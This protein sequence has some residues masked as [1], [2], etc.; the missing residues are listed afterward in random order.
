MSFDK[1]FDYPEVLKKPAEAAMEHALKVKEK[2]KV[3]II[4]NPVR[5]AA[6]ISS[7][8]YDAARALGAEPVM[9][10]QPVKTLVDYAEPAVIA[11]LETEPDVVCSIS[12]EKLGK[13]KKRLKNPEILNG[14]KY[15]HAH[16]F[17]REGKKTVRSFWSPSITMDT[18]VRTVAIDYKD[19]EEECKKVA[20]AVKG[21]EK[22]RV[23]SPAGTD[24]SFSIKGRSPFVDDGNFSSPG[25]G[26]NLPAGEVF[27]SPV[28]GSADGVIVFDGSISLV[29]G[30][31]VPATPV[32]VEVKDGYVTTISGDDPA[33]KNL[34]ES[35]KSG[36]QKA[37]DR[38]QDGSFDRK[39]GESF[40]RNARHI[41]EFGIGLN[42]AAEI[43]GN[44]LE[45]EKVYSTCHFAIGSNYDNDAEALIHLDALVK[46][47]TIEVIKSGKSIIIMKEGKLV[48]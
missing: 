44:M 12:A 10:V 2:E 6:L 45:D 30:V 24:I 4:T 1:V 19:L 23:T 43:V 13:D 21:G 32:R 42:K 17:I 9:V 47:P 27:I 14:Q 3:L 35:L 20:D 37:L 31:A 18:F 40:A 26:G 22:I 11:A 39:T 5:D 36:E 25:S 15:Y 8:L 46:L 38:I 48:L 34:E 33:A 16:D 28:V 7:A 41:G 29:E